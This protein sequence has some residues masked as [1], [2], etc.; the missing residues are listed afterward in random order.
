MKVKHVYSSK[1]PE[2]LKVRAITLYPF[3]FYMDIEDVAK[4]TGIYDHE[5]V[6]VGQIQRVGI[7]RFYLSYL[8]FWWAWKLYGSQEAYY[9]I[10]W[11]KEAYGEEE[12]RIKPLT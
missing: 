7:F 10:Q 3:I 1:I 11:E 12:P 6:H 9:D 8:L 4:A 2:I 5:M